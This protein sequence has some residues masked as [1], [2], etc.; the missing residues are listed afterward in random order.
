M[1]LELFKLIPRSYQSQPSMHLLYMNTQKG[2]E[3]Q[4]K[5]E[6]K[7]MAAIKRYPA[8][9]VI[10]SAMMECILSHTEQQ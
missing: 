4:C 3:L 6:C 5:V 8:S 7:Q 9:A 1:E 10:E 2:K